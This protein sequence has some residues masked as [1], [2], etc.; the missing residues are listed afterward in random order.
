MG[1]SNTVH[2]KY[3][4]FSARSK[5][6][7]NALPHPNLSLPV[8]SKVDN[9]LSSL[10]RNKAHIKKLLPCVITFTFSDDLFFALGGSKTLVKGALVGV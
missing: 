4:P 3:F 5:T 8:L 7:P 6:P 2:K 9:N 10:G 1:G